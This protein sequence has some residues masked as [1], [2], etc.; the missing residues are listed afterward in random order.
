M[1]IAAIVT[2]DGDTIVPLPDG[3][4]VLVFDSEKNSVEKY[5]NPA[6]GMTEGRRSAV[7]NFLLKKQVQVVCSVPETFCSTSCQV[8]VQGGIKF[9]R[10]EPGEKFSTVVQDWQQYAAKAVNTLTPEE[11]FHKKIINE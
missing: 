8:A 3:P 2:N 11:L 4:T 1:R 5:E 10:L 6:I 9:I 7:T